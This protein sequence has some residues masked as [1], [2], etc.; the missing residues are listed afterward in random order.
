MQSVVCGSAEATSPGRLLKIQNPCLSAPRL[1]NWNLHFNKIPGDWNA[2]YSLRSIG[3]LHHFAI[4]NLTTAVP[5]ILFFIFIT[6]FLQ[7]SCT[8]TAHPEKNTN[9][10]LFFEQNL[11]TC[12]SKPQAE[13]VRLIRSWNLTI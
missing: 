6:A 8:K 7:N 1:R 13:I 9:Q 11:V 10:L 2:H 3:L 5:T 4:L 12:S